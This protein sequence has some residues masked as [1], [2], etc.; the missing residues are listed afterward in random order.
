MVVLMQEDYETR[1][2]KRIISSD[3]YGISEGIRPRLEEKR[4]NVVR[5]ENYFRNFNTASVR[6]RT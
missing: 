3:D 4:A 5:S 1:R 6:E 2:S